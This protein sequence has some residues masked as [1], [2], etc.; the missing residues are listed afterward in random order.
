MQLMLVKKITGSTVQIH[1]AK[2][3][4]KKDPVIRSLID[5][6]IFSVFSN[7]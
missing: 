4:K 2:N 3:E 1:G 7:I 6:S 5:D